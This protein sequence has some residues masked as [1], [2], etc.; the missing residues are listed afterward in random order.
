VK[1]V[2]VLGGGPAGLY[3]ALLLARRGIP[4]TVLEKENRAGGLTAG[5]EISGIP[6]DYGS[7]RLHPSTAPDILA[8]L[9]SILGDDLQLRQRNGRIRFDGSWMGFPIS[10]VDM[11][12]EISKS[13]LAR[14]ATG[15]AA[16]TFRPP[17]DGTFAEFVESGLGRPMGELFYFP[18][19]T[20][21]WGVEPGQLSGEQARRRISADT[22]WRLAR[23]ALRRDGA[24]R[25][26]FYPREGFGQIADVLAKSA[27]DAGADVRLGQAVM[28]VVPATD[29][30]EVITEGEAVPGGL[31]LSTIPITV[32]ARFL[33]PPDHVR[34]AMDTLRYRAMVLVYLT[35]RTPQWTRYDAHY[36]P[37]ADVRFTRISEPKNYREGPDP[38]DCTVLC[39]E[40]PADV[41]DGTWSAD[42]SI[43]I[44]QTRDQIVGLGLPDPGNDGHIHRIP[45]AYP[46]YQVGSEVAFDTVASW[47][48]EQEGLVSYG[49]QGLFAHDNT[50]HAMAMARDA[51]ACV[52]D[53]V[54]FDR[55]GWDEARE[56]FTR[57]VVE[58]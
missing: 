53:D 26:F 56:R 13:T 28:G 35:V 37:G 46:V 33:D 5:A 20:K 17:R 18:Y 15:A 2:V 22:P 19:A 43:L 34:E 21:I 38:E 55:S 11:M 31:V 47:L 7:H 39:V 23:K 12:G 41:G 40:I 32:L 52:S 45:H 44:D 14:L 1:G 49:R 9:R 8:D 6:V 57:H 42:D 36:F 3:A 58:D 27:T 16:A 25:Q 30:F 54:E 50:H 29:G 4:V 24:G 10:P 51:V 48:D